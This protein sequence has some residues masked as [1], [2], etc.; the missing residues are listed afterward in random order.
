MKR[1]VLLSILDQAMISVFNLLLN[2]AFIAFASPS[3]FGRFALVL[4]AGFFAVSAQ[5]AL[6][7]MPLNYLLPGREPEEVNASLSMLTSVNLV[8]TL[9]VLATCLGFAVALGAD[10][11]FTIAI[12]FYFF[13]TMIREYVRNLMVVIGMIQRTLVYDAIAIVFSAALALVLWQAMAPEAAVLAGIGGGNLV[14]Y[15]LGG[16]DRK[17]DYRRLG[18]HLKAYYREVWKDTRWA[19][20]GAL[21]NEV[22]RRSYVFIVERMRDAAALGTLNAGRV[23]VSPLMLISSAW[24]RVARPKLVDD[25]GRS[26][27]AGVIRV[28]WT[29]AIAIVGA[30]VLYGLALVV[31]WPCIEKCIFRHRYPGI[32][33]I[34]LCWWI[35]AFVVGITTVAS[36]LMEAR[37]QFRELA[38]VGLAGAIAIPLL[39]LV[40]LSLDFGI[41]SVVLVLCGVQLAELAVFVYLLVRTGAEQTGGADGSADA[42]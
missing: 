38:A 6:V 7:V 31:A 40:F 35:Y 39:L 13:V 3:E 14:A 16:F 28:L 11:L 27:R 4:A 29:G 10:P 1:A 5:N 15:F 36:T 20:Q 2:L 33:T 21:Q 12:L 30:S 25:L 19:L 8:L 23:G 32:E 34:L 22:V 37:R 9:A 24:S 42:P 26:D 17:A 41:A 18:R